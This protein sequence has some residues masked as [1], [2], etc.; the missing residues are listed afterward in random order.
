VVPGPAGLATAAENTSS[1]PLD[2]T[3]HPFF[4]NYAS[5]GPWRVRCHTFSG[6]T[7]QIWKIRCYP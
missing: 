6:S 7:A 1:V 3:P 4:T 2:P 5:P